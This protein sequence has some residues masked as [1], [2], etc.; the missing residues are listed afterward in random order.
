M[1]RDSVARGN[2]V[3]RFD[4]LEITQ[5][6]LC[7]QYQRFGIDTILSGESRRS[8]DSALDEQNDA[9]ELLTHSSIISFLGVELRL[10]SRALHCG[11]R[12]LPRG[13]RLRDIVEV[14]RA[15]FALMLG[16]R[17]AVIL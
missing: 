1:A 14:A 9:N 3:S 6:H 2:Q 12:R 5:H 15:H 8:S 13:D 7:R 11:Y 17:V 4:P 10:F 16:R